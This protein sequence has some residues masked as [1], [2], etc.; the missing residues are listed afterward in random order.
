LILYII[1]TFLCSTNLCSYINLIN[2]SFLKFIYKKNQCS[3]TLMFI[4]TQL[5][6]HT[7][8]S[9][10]I[11]F[12]RKYQIERRV[13][14]SRLIYSENR[15]RVSEYILRS[16]KSSHTSLD[17][18]HSSFSRDGSA[19]TFAVTQLVSRSNGS[20]RNVMSH[21]H[22]DG[23]L[24]LLTCGTHQCPICADTRNCSVHHMINFISFETKDF[25][26][27]TPYLIL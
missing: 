17:T 12:H 10:I 19:R 11:T 22:A 2:P 8:N 3:S 25:T 15:F 13:S 20:K 1:S 27:S 16:H 7:H 9:K 6:M 14:F 18:K 21:E 23:M 5:E 26:Q 24:N 4:Q